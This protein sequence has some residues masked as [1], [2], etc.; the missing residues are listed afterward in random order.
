[1]YNFSY[2]VIKEEIIEFENDWDCQDADSILIQEKL[3]KLMEN[4]H[5]INISF[6]RK[7][8]KKKGSKYSIERLKMITDIEVPLPGLKM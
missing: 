1:M 2:K 4:V 6:K 7:L 3:T 8:G 5:L